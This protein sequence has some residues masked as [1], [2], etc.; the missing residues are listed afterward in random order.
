MAHATPA[1]VAA[2]LGRGLT[3]GESDQV[4]A[5][6]ED[7]EATILSKLPDLL[8]TVGTNPVL[9]QALTSVECAVALRA[10]RI[11]DAVQSAYPTTENWSA[12]S[13]SSRANVTV[14][15]TEW[16]KLGLTWYKSFRV[17]ENDT[18]LPPGFFPDRNPAWG[19]WWNTGEY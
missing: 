10:S 9:S 7:A 11:T 8:T 2:R 19:P 4:A 13:G 14:L 17:N 18:T 1:D 6:L 15:D 3:G 12:P 16:R 5:Y